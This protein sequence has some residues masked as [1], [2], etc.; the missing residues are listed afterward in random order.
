MLLIFLVIFL[1][2]A[3]MAVHRL[4]EIVRKLSTIEKNAAFLA[5]EVGK[6]SWQQLGSSNS[7]ETNPNE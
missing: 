5:Q 1:I 7:A 2:L 3:C 6:G 4:G